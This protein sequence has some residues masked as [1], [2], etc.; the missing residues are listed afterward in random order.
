MTVPMEIYLDAPYHCLLTTTKATSVEDFLAQTSV[1]KQEDEKK[2][3]EE[4]GLNC[5]NNDVGK[6]EDEE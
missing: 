5:S 3:E 6:R 2:D 1:G 4:N